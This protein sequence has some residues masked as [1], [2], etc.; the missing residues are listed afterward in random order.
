MSDIVRLV[1]L[2]VSVLEELKRLDLVI[3]TSSTRPS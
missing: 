2:E 3:F 1:R